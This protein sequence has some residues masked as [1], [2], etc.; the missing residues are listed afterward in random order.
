M[1]ASK[2]A[3]A[4]LSFTHFRPFSSASMPSLSPSFSSRL[5]PHPPDL[6]KWVRRE[7]GFVHHA[8]NIAP[9]PGA[10]TGLG[11]LAS[12]H[13][14]K[15]SELI[16]L[17]HNLPLRFESPEAGDSDEA[18]S[19][20]VNLA[21]QVP[22][23]LWSMKLGLKL[24]KERAKV[25]SFWWAY[26]G[27]LPEVF[28]VPI[29]FPG[30]DIKN[31]QYAPLLY[32]VNKR[33]RFL[34]D[35]EKEVKRTLDSIKPENHP[36]GGQT[37][38]ASSLGWAM[39]AVSSRAFRLYS[40]NLTDST[41]TSV[42]MMLPLIDM[43]NHSFNSNARIIQEQDAS[44]KLKVKVVAET[45][46][47]ENA[48]LTLNYGCLDNDLFLL[49][50]GFVVPSNQYDYIELKYDEAL[51]EAA[52]IVAGI[53]SE[54]FSSPAP[55]QRLILTK[56]NLHGE[57]ALLKVSI[58]GSEIVDGRLLAA[59]RVLLSV[60]EEMVQKH[61]LSVLKSLS[62]EAPLGIANEVAALRTVIALC[63][64]ALGHFPTKIMDDETLL[65]KC[66]SETSK[67]AI[68]FRLQKKSV[69]IDVM[70]NLTRRVKLL[71]SKAVSQG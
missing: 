61:D 4:S 30:D 35:F 58:G 68:Q 39:A 34:L 33:C 65:K 21:R 71:S 70:S 27:N 69:I 53:S 25:G 15:G 48:P 13:I 60:D 18:D 56:L 37:V 59:L 10:H 49:D 63:V 45:E 54:N 47:E 62:A 42:P 2:T 40:K 9:A 11:L 28:T 19:V 16:I 46:I 38:D 31:L 64:I 22:E 55:W 29:F 8:L 36:F 41:P 17:P 3:M 14:P 51:L 57:A 32:Q 43:C 7:G 52:S 50:Y 44:M 24:L 20:L 66:E 12:H 1:T 6:I 67:L 5:V 26:I 23:E